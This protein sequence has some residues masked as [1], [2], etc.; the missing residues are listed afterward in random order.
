VKNRW[1]SR[2]VRFGSVQDVGMEWAEFLCLKKQ[3][4][5]KDYLSLLFATGAFGI[6][7]GYLGSLEGQC[8]SYLFG[9]AQHS[10]RT[11]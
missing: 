3:L 2:Q 1:E 8:L 6:F 7:Q 9:R 5:E 11:S 10:S 4:E